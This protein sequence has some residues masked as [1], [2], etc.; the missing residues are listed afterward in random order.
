MLEAQTSTRMIDD[1]YC[2]IHVKILEVNGIKIT[3]LQRTKCG[4]PYAGA[5][6]IAK[7]R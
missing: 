6:S 5:L 3:A 4:S 7:R 1:G 2:K